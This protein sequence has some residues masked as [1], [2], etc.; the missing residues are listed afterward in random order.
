MITTQHKDRNP[1]LPLALLP[2]SEQSKEVPLTPLNTKRHSSQLLRL[3][4]HEKPNRPSGSNHHSPARLKANVDDG[5][6]PE[7]SHQREREYPK[8]EKT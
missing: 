5:V 2:R 4:P 3:H 7:M 1:K 8:F 6:P